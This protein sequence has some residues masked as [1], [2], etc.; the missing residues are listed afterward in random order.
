MPDDR[1]VP[2]PPDL[3][4]IGLAILTLLVDEREARIATDKTAPPAEVL[5]DK[6]GLN[7]TQIAGLLRK[8]P[9]AVRMTL[10]RARAAAA[11]AKS[12]GKGK[13]S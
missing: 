5:L 8:Q 11:K 9:S 10:S 2:S 12:P 6:V 13:G 7:S 4:A 1:Q 3:S